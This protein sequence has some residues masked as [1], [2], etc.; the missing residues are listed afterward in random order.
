MAEIQIERKKGGGLAWLWVL[1]ALLL[2][3]L[4]LWMFWPRAEVIRPMEPLAVGTG[5]VLTGTAPA[6]PAP[7][8]PAPAG[9]SEPTIAAINA[10]PQ[11]WIGREFSGVVN[12]T[13]VPTDRGF[14]IEQ[15]GQRLFALVHDQPA[16]VPIEIKSGQRLRLRGTVRD[17]SFLPQLP[18]ETLTSATE[19]IVR[20][21]PAY[22]V[23]GETAIEILQ[24][25]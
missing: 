20:Q 6:E 16:E 18:G 14:W 8:E 21:Q 22:V 23:A 9:G 3:A 4:L 5:T 11:Q 17:A 12:V 2:I 15:E 19:Q 10:N 25:P 13:D 7:A 1:L 24:Q